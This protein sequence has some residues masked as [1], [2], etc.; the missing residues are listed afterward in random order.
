LH[1]LWLDARHHQ[2]EP[3]V[4]SL[5]LQLALAFSCL[6][7]L[8]GALMLPIGSRNMR[9]DARIRMLRNPNGHA[10]Q[11]AEAQAPLW[12]RLVG[13][14]G[15]VVLRSG[16]LSV[17]ATDDLRK[18]LVASGNRGG[19]AL[20]L[21]IGA[22]LLLV[23]GLPLLGWIVIK[24]LNLGISPVLVMG[25]CAVVGLLVPDYLVRSIRK[26][27]LRAVEAGMPAVLDM[28]I[29]CAEA[30]MALEAGFERV[31]LEAEDGAQ[32]AASELRITAVEMKVLADRTQA[33]MNMGTRT[34]LDSLIRL[35]A[36]L[37]QSLK[38]GTP[39]VQAL[40]LLAAEMRQI[41]LNRFE[42]RAAKIPVL[43][44]IPMIVFILPCI[45]IVVGGPAALE[46]MHTV[47]AP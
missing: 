45:F 19:P 7:A 4:N 38:Y 32:A 9:I 20:A 43:L 44:T 47:M 14:L 37:G 15:Q 16:L 24:T 36:V 22:K 8:A 11:S 1:G 5:Y 26:R 25:L 29:I 30:G 6:C 18:T 3:V 41:A 23:F 12:M 13:G 35:G 17:K 46:V 21:F 27:Y 10:S 39:L 42:A 31:A 28:L 34:G 2:K 33:L 40:R